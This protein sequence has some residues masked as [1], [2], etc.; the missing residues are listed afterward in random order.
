MKETE[1]FGR[2]C[3]FKRPNAHAFCFQMVD[4]GN[5][6][7]AMNIDV[8]PNPN[9]RPDWAKK[10]TLQIDVDECAELVAFL[11]GHFQTIDLSYHGEH[12]NRSVIL[13]KVCNE[14]GEQVSVSMLIGGKNAG[15]IY[16]RKGE[17]FSLYKL[18]N[19]LLSKY[20]S[21]SER[22]LILSIKTFFG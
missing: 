16:L 20:Y 1:Q 3:V 15:Y 7:L 13:K 11:L 2:K 17:A 22:D 18:A 10:N 6:N 8:A 14:H 4:R 19:A 21:Q 12:N 5:R 9:N